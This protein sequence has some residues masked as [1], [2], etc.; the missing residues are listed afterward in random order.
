MTTLPS[1]HATPVARLVWRLAFLLTL[2]PCAAAG[3]PR[4]SRAAP[5][6]CLAAAHEL[7]DRTGLATVREAID[8]ACPCTHFSG[9]PGN[10]RSAYRR[11]ARQV[12]DATLAAGTLRRECR[13]AA[14]RAYSDTTCGT[15]GRVACGRVTPAARARP[16]TCRIALVESCRSGGAYTET[17]CGEETHCS[18]VIEETAG[19]CVATERSAYAPGWSAVHADASN[20]DYSPVQGATDLTL[21]W[22][23]R[24]DGAINLGPTIGPDGRVYVTDNSNDAGCHLHVLDGA[25]G[26]TIWCS[27][28]VDR[29]A[30]ASSPLLDRDGRIFLADGTAMHA[31]DRDGNVLWKTPIVGVP[32]SAQFTPEGRL[33][34]ITHI[35]RIYVLRRE[36][37]TPMLPPLEL[38]PGRTW[39]PAE[40]MAACLQGRAGCPSANTLAVD[41][42]TGRFFFTFFAPGAP[43]AGMRAMRYAEDP[44]PSLTALWSNDDLPGGSAS[45]PD[46]SADGTRLYVTDNVDAM[47][48]LDAATGARI[49]R[50]PIGGAPGGSPSLSPDGVL[51]P[52]GSAQGVMLALRDDGPSASLLWR[53]ETMLNRGVPTQAAGGISYAT[54]SAGGYL[55]DLV[56]LD[57]ATGAVLDRERLPGSTVFTVGTTVG[58][59]GTV[60]VPT[61]LG[62]LFAYAP[63]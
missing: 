35:G 38:I 5:D 51:M 11:C 13:T 50:F 33:I 60:F 28:K 15:T 10:D 45:S 42:A 2:A 43:Q 22:Q 14:T 34:F 52:S 23:V 16:V 53:D 26:G 32:L 37:G 63:G 39:T 62:H 18:D 56:V 59:D 29:F 21:R 36:T 47:H 3:V 49:W 58:P 12:R 46:L 41:Q 48:A 17:A 54:V 9:A 40:S 24:L 44:A 31:F 61:F 55:N 8:A 25:T 6:G 4:E 57:T 7:R 19:T 27:S 30:V 20:T 1:A